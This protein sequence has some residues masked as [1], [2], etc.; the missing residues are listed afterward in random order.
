MFGEI[1][2]YLSY[3]TQENTSLGGQIKLKIQAN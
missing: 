2:N 3:A 1:Q